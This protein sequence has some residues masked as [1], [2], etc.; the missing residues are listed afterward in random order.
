[1][2]W[3][4]LEVALFD[5]AGVTMNSRAK[6]G[7]GRLLKKAHNSQSKVNGRAS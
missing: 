6:F 1:M 7:T 5:R 3:D 4:L 2:S